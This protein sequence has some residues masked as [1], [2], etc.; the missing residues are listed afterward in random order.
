M[1]AAFGFS[2]ARND[3]LVIRLVIEVEMKS[4]LLTGS[5]GY[6]G[7][8]VSHALSQSGAKVIAVDRAV[9][10]SVD[11]D[12]HIAAN[13]LDAN[14]DLI[15]LIGYVPDVCLHL[16]WRNGFNHNDP[17]HIDDLSLHFSFL[18]RMAKA[19][20]PQ[21]AAMGSMHEVGYW[22]GAITEDT[23]CN[24][25]SLYGV[26]KNALRESLAIE[27]P[28]L[29][30]VFQWLRGY[31]V[32]GDDERAQSI[33]GKLLTAAKNGERVFPFTSGRNLY[34]FLSV[35]ELAEQIAAVVMQDEVAGVIN[36]CSGNP[37]SLANQVEWFIE[38]RDLDIEL[39]YGAFPDR[40][41]DSPGVWGDSTKIEMIMSAQ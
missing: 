20:L 1:L 9:D 39:E 17:C 41:Y 26:A 4:I 23:P 8:H 22:E 32:Y 29:G 35:T 7:R 21:I 25:L 13:V 27:L 31:Y 2:H 16:A 36:C 34:D 6:I 18:L 19:G 3:I 40:P 33:F 11:A 14:V 30:V 12:V 15:E 10:Q 28:K 38:T 24:P 37:V 5:N